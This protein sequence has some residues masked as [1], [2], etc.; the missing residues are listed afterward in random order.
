MKHK[1]TVTKHPGKLHIALRQMPECVWCAD[2][3]VC[4]YCK[5]VAGVRCGVCFEKGWTNRAKY[6]SAPAEKRGRS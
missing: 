2:T 4:P 1:S 6:N 5:G 3:G